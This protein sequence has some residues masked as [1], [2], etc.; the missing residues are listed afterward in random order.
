MHRAALVA[1]LPLP[2]PGLSV[3]QFFQNKQ[4][5]SLE[6]FWERKAKQSVMQLSTGPFLLLLETY[7]LSL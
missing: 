2:D 5:Q 4:T 7:F 3:I 1:T 6:P